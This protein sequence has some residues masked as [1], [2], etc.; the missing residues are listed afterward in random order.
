MQRDPAAVKART[1]PARPLSHDPARL[2]R[3][4][5]AAALT[6]A[7]LAERAGTSKSN[8]SE[9]ENGFHGPTPGLLGRLAAALGC[10]TTD[11][12]PDEAA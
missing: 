7:E 9:L 6:L 2:R 10:Q 1:A 4:R 11:L 3:R 5:I 12:M 8:L